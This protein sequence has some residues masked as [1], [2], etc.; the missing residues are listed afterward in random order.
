MKKLVFLVAF[1]LFSLSVN[2][3]GFPP[4]KYGNIGSKKKITYDYNSGIWLLGADK[5]GNNY[6]I[7]TKNAENNYEYLNSNG[8]YA[9]STDCDYEFITDGK[10]YCYSNE[11][12]RFYLLGLSDSSAITK[13]PLTIE[14]VAQ[15]LPKYKIIKLSDFSKSTNAYKLKKHFG[16]LKVFI[17]NDTDNTF[18]DYTYT[19]GNADFDKYLLNGFINIKSSGM[20]Q[21]SSNYNNSSEIPWYVLLIR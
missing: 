13:T 7:K 14:E 11:D 6:F 5:T 2:A 10:F 9:F 18:P 3:N 20:I 21:F 19:S 16:S 4:M 8:E 1:L 12:L 17:F 15:L